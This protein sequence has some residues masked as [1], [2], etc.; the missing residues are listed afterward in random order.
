MLAA[1]IAVRKLSALRKEIYTPT[2]VPGRSQSSKVVQG[3]TLTAVAI[4]VLALVVTPDVWNG[5][6]S[7][8]FFGGVTFYF[9]VVTSWDHKQLKA[10]GVDTASMRKVLFL[11]VLAILPFALI[12][13]FPV[14]AT[15][16]K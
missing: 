6:L 3:V 11:R 12:V 15:V 1:M 8:A 10:A 16:Q 14:K 7:V 13:S 5:L 2:Q 9:L 4:L